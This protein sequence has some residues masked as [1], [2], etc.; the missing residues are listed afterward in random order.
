MRTLIVLC[1]GSREI[2]E[3]PLYL[4]KHPEGMLIAEK[5]IEGIQPESYDRIIYTILKSADQEYNATKKLLS[6]VGKKYPIEVV[7]LDE[8]TNGPADT[9]Y[10][11]IKKANV[12]GEFAVRDSLNTISVSVTY[13]GNFLAGLDL[14]TYNEEVF[15]IKSKSFIVINEQNQVLDVVEKKFR[16]DMISVGL[17]GFKEVKDFLLAYEKL[18]DFNYPIKKLYLSNIISYLIGYKQRIFHCIEVKEYE[19]WGTEETWRILQKQYEI[20]F[21]NL[22]EIVSN[23]KENI[24][25]T[26]I[27]IFCKKKNNKASYVF[28]TS[29]ND[30]NSEKLKKM[31][32][33]K[34]IKCL[35]VINSC[36]VTDIKV[37]IENKKELNSALIG[38]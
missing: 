31:L 24:E 7:V 8:K 9:V 26:I 11:T 16:S 4:N 36:P 21:V 18:K 10:E 29:R 19:D 25:K 30:I 32:N 37:F 22:D 6:S 14:T 3:K 23:V 27:E 12:K 2:N 33:Q 13:S 28:F 5:T 38:V 15:N 20:C 1:A 35:G 34:N 17:Y